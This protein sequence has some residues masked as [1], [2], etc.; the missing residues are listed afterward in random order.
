MIDDGVLIKTI[1]R[2]RSR[3]YI[4]MR[5]QNERLRRRTLFGRALII[6][7]V[8]IGGV[9]TRTYQ[10]DAC[11]FASE[12]RQKYVRQYQHSRDSRTITYIIGCIRK[13][14]LCTHERSCEYHSTLMTI[15]IIFYTHAFGK[16]PAAIDTQT[17]T[18]VRVHFCVNVA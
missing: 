14:S 9:C 17:N 11:K 13:C 7:H 8:C 16:R 18:Y 3:L 6:N 15:Y 10:R 5:E 1:N 12:F 4:G 2:R